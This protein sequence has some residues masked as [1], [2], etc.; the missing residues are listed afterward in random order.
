MMN[1]V[2]LIGRLTRDPEMRYTPQGVAVTRFT[3]AVDRPVANAQG[4]R[5]ADF[6]D[7]VAWRKLAE[8]VANHLHK[9]RLVAVRGRLHI[10]SWEGQDGQRRRRAEVVA[11]DVRFLDRARVDQH[12]EREPGEDDLFAGQFPEAG[13]EGEDVPF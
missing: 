5:E 6:I 9:G 3:L 4:E 8:T 13:A 10:Q 2:V 1:L 12:R 11:D 7:V